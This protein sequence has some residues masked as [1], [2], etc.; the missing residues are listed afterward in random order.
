MIPLIE[1]ACRG[2]NDC[3]IRAYSERVV[4]VASTMMRTPA[5]SRPFVSKSRAASTREIASRCS[6]VAMTMAGK[7]SDEPLAKELADDLFVRSRVLGD[8]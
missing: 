7:T 6:G 1:Q 8:E 2:R 5:D 3:L 4:S